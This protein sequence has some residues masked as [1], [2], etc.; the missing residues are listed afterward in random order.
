MKKLSL[1]LVLAIFFFSCDNFN[2]KETSDDKETIEVI[3]E[4]TIEQIEQKAE[5][6]Q[7]KTEELNKEIDE[8]TKD[9]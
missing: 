1:L 6:V 7:K 8:L 2:K 3:D 4:T 5:E 9:L